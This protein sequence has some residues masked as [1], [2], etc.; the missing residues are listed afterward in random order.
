MTE[1]QKSLSLVGNEDSNSKTI[2]EEESRSKLI[3]GKE[4]LFNVKY[5]LN[6]LFDTQNILKDIVFEYC[7]KSKYT[8]IKDLNCDKSPNEDNNRKSIID[9]IIS[10]DNELLSEPDQIF[11]ENAAKNLLEY[12]K[13]I[14]NNL[15][16]LN[17]NILPKIITHKISYFFCHLQINTIENFIHNRLYPEY[18]QHRKE[19]L[20]NLLD[21][22]KLELEEINKLILD[23]L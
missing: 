12:D 14:K 16:L 17:Q 20:L 13:I 3:I 21:K 10:E 2:G 1:N 5:L 4:Y 15:E 8:K 7:L 23:T 22:Y 9:Y 19:I 11:I 18:H 6:I